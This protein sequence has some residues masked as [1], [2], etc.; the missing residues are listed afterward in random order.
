MTTVSEF[1]AM[2][3]EEIAEPLDYPR[4]PGLSPEELRK[5]NEGYRYACDLTLSAEPEWDDE[6]WLTVNSDCVPQFCVLANSLDPRDRG[7]HDAY[8]WIL[9][10]LKSIKNEAKDASNPWSIVRA[11]VEGESTP[12]GVLQTAIDAITV[13]QRGGGSEALSIIRSC[14][15]APDSVLIPRARYNYLLDMEKAVIEFTE[16]ITKWEEE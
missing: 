16:S 11:W 13:E 1:K 4:V 6:D 14:F 8:T 7:K 10:E 9:G 12:A 2:L 15:D 5:Y 3:R